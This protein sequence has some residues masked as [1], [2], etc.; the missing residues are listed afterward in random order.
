MITFQWMLEFYANCAEHDISYLC[1]RYIQK[2]NQKQ[3]V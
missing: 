2:P 1:F 3:K